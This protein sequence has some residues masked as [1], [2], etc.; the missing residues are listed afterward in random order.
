MFIAQLRG[1]LSRPEED[2]ED[3]L[4]SNVFGIWRYLPPTLGLVQFL[5][6]AKRVDGK[7]LAVPSDVSVANLEFWPRLDYPDAKGAEPDVLISYSDNDDTK[8]L[9]MVEAKYK[10]GKSSFADYADKRPN[11]QLAREMQSLHLLARREGTDRYA[12]VYVTAH[13]TMPRNDVQEAVEELL[14]KASE[15]G[16]DRFYWTTWRYL[17]RILAEAQSTS[18]DSIAKSLLADLRELLEGMGLTFYQ[19][20]CSNGWSLGPSW[21]FQVSKATFGAWKPFRIGAYTFGLLRNAFQWIG[22]T[23]KQFQGWRW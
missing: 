5:G 14:D 16:T 9:V 6:T 22:P 11:D 3:L 23:A 1:K 12:L 20:I 18:E 21:E 8:C 19:G 10:S 15:A 7:E 2:M 13:T 4:T 17:P